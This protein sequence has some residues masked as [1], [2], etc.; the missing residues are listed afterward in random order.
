MNTKPKTAGLVLAVLL[1]GICVFAGGTQEAAADSPAATSNELTGLASVAAELGVTENELAEALGDPSKGKPDFDT[2]AQELGVS[3]DKLERLLM[4][5]GGESV[6]TAPYHISLNGID[7]EITYEVFDWDELPSDVNYERQPI[8]SFTDAEENTH[9][10]EAVFVSSGNLNWYQAAYLAENAGGYLASPTSDEENAFVFSLIDDEKYF[11]SF[12]EEGEH[13]GISIGPF[14]GGYQI[15]GSVEPAGGWTWLS[16]ESMDYTN[17]AVNLDDGIIDK[18]PRPN[19][20]PND[21]GV[22]Q[23]IMGFGEMNLPVP[24]WGDYM[25]NVGTYGLTRS[26][27]NSYGFIIEYELDPR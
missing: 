19:D 27:G 18:D 7:F 26:P 20:Q 23:P 16:G 14:L 1:A 3:A 24:T 5:E 25:E 17:W 8:Q 12:P 9:Y 11:W 13:Y 2:A 10:Y 6:E 15:E 22:G 21:S 4:Q